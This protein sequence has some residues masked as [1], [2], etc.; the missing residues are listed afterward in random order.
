MDVFRE[1]R[2]RAPRDEVGRARGVVEL[3]MG[4]L[5]RFELLDEGVVLDVADRR[6]VE[7]VV[8]L[9]VLANLVAK[10]LDASAQSVVTARG[11]P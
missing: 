1:G 7:D 8:A 4:G 3:G 5:E 10:A 11:N 2:R 6:L 9:V